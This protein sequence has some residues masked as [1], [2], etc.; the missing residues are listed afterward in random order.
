MGPGAAA[1]DITQPTHEGIYMYAMLPRGLQGHPM[2]V[3]SLGCLFLLQL[4]HGSALLLV[5]PADEPRF[6]SHC[7]ACG[8]LAQWGHPCVLHPATDC[9]E[10]N[11][12]ATTIAGEVI[13]AIT[14]LTG[15]PAT[16]EQIELA[17]QISA[18]EPFEPPTQIARRVTSDLIDR[19]E[20]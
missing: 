2:P 10:E 14:V 16:N 15:Q 19:R 18:T 17:A 6:C 4:R 5:P 20:T 9:P 12:C 13:R 11:W 3:C 7:L 1:S 8:Q